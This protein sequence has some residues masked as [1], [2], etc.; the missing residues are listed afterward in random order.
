[1]RNPFKKYNG[2]KQKEFDGDWG[3]IMVARNMEHA[4]YGDVNVELHFSKSVYMPAG[5]EL[6]KIITMKSK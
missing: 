1:M 3:N 5:I 6:R 4:T 2:V